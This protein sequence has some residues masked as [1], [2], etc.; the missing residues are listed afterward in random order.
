MLDI[1]KALT[2]MGFSK[3]EQQSVTSV[4]RTLQRVLSMK[5]KALEENGNI[6]PT[7]IKELMLFKDWYV[8]WKEVTKTKPKAIEE[9]FTETIWENYLL[10]ISIDIRRLLLK[11]LLLKL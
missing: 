4:V 5:R 1:T 10:E 6:S 8:E 9:A 7:A 3:Q 2:I 11:P